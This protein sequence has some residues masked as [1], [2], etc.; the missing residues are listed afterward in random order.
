[1]GYKLLLGAGVEVGVGVGSL[2][3]SQANPD[4]CK[5]PGINTR[6]IL[7]IL[8]LSLRSLVR[9]GCSGELWLS[10]VRAITKRSYLL[11]GSPRSLL[12]FFQDYYIA[13]NLF[14][15]GL[16]TPYMITP[17]TLRC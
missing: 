2:S 15:V 10:I 6:A 17:V 12:S 9:G 4:T 11:S 14:I 3:L 16:P 13:G 1:M 7:S 8:N 5:M